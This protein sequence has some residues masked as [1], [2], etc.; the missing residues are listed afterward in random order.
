MVQET[1][2]EIRKALQQ[3]EGGTRQIQSRRT[4]RGSRVVKNREKGKVFRRNSMCTGPGVEKM[5][6]D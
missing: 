5:L 1:K 4:V 2:K 6:A 3:E